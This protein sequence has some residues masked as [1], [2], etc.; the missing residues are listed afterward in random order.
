[1]SR[2]GDIS[3]IDSLSDL[4]MLRGKKRS[5]GELHA[6]S[7]AVFRDYGF[8]DNSGICLI[9]EFCGSNRRNDRIKNLFIKSCLR[10][11]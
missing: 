4:T 11:Q 9:W 1:M 8:T 3:I 10:I 6:E 5:D 7:E 2:R